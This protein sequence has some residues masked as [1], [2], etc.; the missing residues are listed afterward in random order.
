MGRQARYYL[1][2]H[3]LLKLGDRGRTAGGLHTASSPPGCSTTVHLAPHAIQPTDAFIDVALSTNL[4]SASPKALRKSSGVTDPTAP[5]R[6]RSESLTHSGVFGVGVVIV[7]PCLDLKR[8]KK[9]L[10]NFSPAICQFLQFLCAYQIMV[11]VPQY[12]HYA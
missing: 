11:T 2:K 6:A 10:D 4:I 1:F 12:P 7:V 8:L 3:A 5:S 9:P